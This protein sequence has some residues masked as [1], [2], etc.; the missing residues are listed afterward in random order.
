MQAYIT[1]PSLSP[2]S[3]TWRFAL[4]ATML[5]ACLLAILAGATPTTA[6]DAWFRDSD[7]V[8]GY[9][10]GN[11]VFGDLDADGD[12][13]AMTG[14][15]LWRNDGNMVFNPAGR[16]GGANASV[17]ELADLDGDADLDVLLED[18]TSVTLWRNNSGLSFLRASTLA[19][20][21]DFG[22]GV[23]DL[24]GDGDFDLLAISMS[25]FKQHA[26]WQNDGDFNFRRVKQFGSVEDGPYDHADVALGDIDD[27]GDLDAVV[28]ECWAFLQ[29]VRV[30]EKR[31]R[32]S[33][34][35]CG[36]REVLSLCPC[37]R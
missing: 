20:L 23:G 5:A 34:C 6:Q 7:A 32:L 37:S 15:E 9:G 16:L 30:M 36:H 25:Y 8:L 22:L 14:N 18:G 26:L 33:V 19:G 13:D 24:D 12:L 35:T 29:G 21:G 1:K 17:R 27:D 2:T 10:G 31:G 11:V 28:T 3:I 4:H